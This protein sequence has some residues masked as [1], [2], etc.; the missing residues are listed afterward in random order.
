M[1]IADIGL[2]AV[3][4]ISPALPPF[5]V[6]QA[7]LETGTNKWLW[8]VASILCYLVLIYIYW[9]IFSEKKINVMVVY[10]IIKIAS[11][12]VAL[13][14]GSVLFGYR[15]NWESTLGVILGIVSIMLLSKNSGH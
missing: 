12:M 13:V 11:I 4:A 7:I 10:F 15:L 2:L 6:K 5:L 1:D 3:G 9:L 8:I 14:I